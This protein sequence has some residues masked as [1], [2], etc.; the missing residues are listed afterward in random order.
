MK[1]HC[2]Y[3][4]KY[5]KAEVSKR[6]GENSVLKILKV[7]LI[8][9]LSFAIYVPSL[10]AQTGSG[11]LENIELNPQNNSKDINPDTHLIITF[12]NAAVLG[13]QGKIRVFDVATGELVDSLDMS[14]APGPRNTRTPWPYDTII[15]KGIPDSLYTVY[16]PDRN[17]S[18]VYQ[19]N[20]IG[21]NEKS[22]ACHFYPVLLNGNTATICLHNNQLDYNK[23]YYVTIDPEVFPFKDGSFPG[24]KD[25][26][27]WT[28][29]TKKEAP[30]ANASKLVVAADGSGDFN[31]VQGAFDFIPLNNTMPRTIYIRNGVYE[32]MVIIRNKNNITVI[33]EDRDKTIIQYANNGVFNYRRYEF[34]VASSNDIKLVNF[35]TISLGDAPAQAEGLCIKGLRNQVH[36]VTIIG[37]GDA[38]QAGGTMYMSQSSIEGWGDNVLGAG[39]YFN[40]C[41]FITIYGPH[42]WARNKEGSPGYLLYKCR[43]W[44]KGDSAAT[45]STFARAPI[46]PHY[47]FPY[48]ETVLIN[49]AIAGVPP[50]GWGESND[51]CKDSHCWEYNSV[52]L[53]DGSPADVSHRVPYSRQ[54]TMEKDSQLIADYSNP[55]YF[56]KGWTPELAPV[57][58]SQPQSCS[59]QKGQ[60]VEFKVQIAAVPEVSY[61][62]YFNNKPI[63]GATSSILKVESVNAKDN[64][65]Y[66]VVIKNELGSV[67][68]QKAKLNI[69]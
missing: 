5:C 18:H 29:S 21:G 37:S 32:E 10:Y 3:Y 2:S 55:T 17:K 41:D 60:S 38:V 48:T 53:K 22:D 27:S 63:A 14:I 65:S 26:I 23:T 69:L 35:S 58:L 4:Q 34:T 45:V 31:T 7:Q 50:S 28:F 57:I 62:W 15:Y 59:V 6:K 13:N 20:Y 68:S 47:R 42:L 46:K 9:V 66:S 49:C 11:M 61:Q 54:L 51:P 19:I 8:V 67:T 36:H 64:G 24:I 40:K 30:S 16:K 43:L 39:V 12:K 44:L 25:K 1:L 56:L 33:G 52:N